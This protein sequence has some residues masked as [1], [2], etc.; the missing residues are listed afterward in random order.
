MTIGRLERVALREVWKHEALDFTRW[1]QDNVEI[2]NDELDIT[3]ANVEREQAA[4]SFSVDLVG[5]D[6]AGNPVVIENQLG[7]S[8]HDHLGKL[9]TY[10]TAF[11]AKTA[12]WIV[13]HPRPEHI[14]AV[15]WLN[16][17]TPAAFYLFKVEAVRI[18]DSLPAPFLTKIVGPSKE[19]REVGDTKKDLAERHHIRLRFWDQLLTRA[20]QRTPLH[21]AISPSHQNWLYAG[22]GRS[23]VTFSY[24]ILERGARVGLHIDSPSAESNLSMFDYLYDRKPGI[25]NA[26]AGSLEWHRDEERRASRIVCTIDAGGYRDDEERWP[27]IQKAMIEAMVRLETALQPYIDHLPK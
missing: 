4:G 6:E 18:G 13:S 9:I 14:T 17:S 7:K 2:L 21:D 20:R 1:L 22:A 12:V 11:E 24:F 10:L 16:Q 27:A 26:F 25:E 3:I 5:E 8:D 19:S 23:G 15:A